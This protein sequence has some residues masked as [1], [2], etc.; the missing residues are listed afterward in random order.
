MAGECKALIAGEGQWARAAAY[1]G[2][3]GQ[4]R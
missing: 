1:R 3:G 4:A 2:A